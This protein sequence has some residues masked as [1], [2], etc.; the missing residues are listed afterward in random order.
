MIDVTGQSDRKMQ[1]LQLFVEQCCEPGVYIVARDLYARY[2]DWMTVAECR[3]WPY[4]KWLGIMERISP[5]DR[6]SINGRLTTI[7]IGLR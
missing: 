4:R 3:P 1:H 5:R 6:R 2:V 7:V